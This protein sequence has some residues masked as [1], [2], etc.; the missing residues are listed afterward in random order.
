LTI[1]DDEAAIIATDA[2]FSQHKKHVLDYRYG[3]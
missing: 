2:G 3:M 1:D